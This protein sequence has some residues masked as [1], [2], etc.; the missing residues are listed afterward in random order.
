MSDDSK[1]QKKS[2]ILAVENVRRIAEQLRTERNDAVALGQ[3]RREQLSTAISLIKEAL[4]H[5]ATLPGDLC[6][7]MEAFLRDPEL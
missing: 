6:G 4:S 1:P 2:E 7:R 5:R 3:V